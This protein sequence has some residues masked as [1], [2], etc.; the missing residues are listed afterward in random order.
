MSPSEW[1]ATADMAFWGGFW[2]GM[3]V[4]STAA[5]LAVAAVRYMQEPK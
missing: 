5:L 3:I 1:A 2:F 4:A